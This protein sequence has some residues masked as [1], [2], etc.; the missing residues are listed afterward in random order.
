[1]WFD[2]LLQLGRESAHISQYQ[3]LM[4]PKPEP[5]QRKVLW[6]VFRKP[7]PEVAA[8]KPFGAAKTPQGEKDPLGRT[9]VAHSLSP[10]SKKQVI[11]QPRHPEPIPEDIPAPNVADMPPEPTPVRKAELK[12]F[13][14]PPPARPK[15]DPAPVVEPP[16]PAR[17]SVADL[18]DEQILREL[19]RQALEQAKRPSLRQFTPPS[20]E[21][22]KT[23]PAL[24]LEPP[25]PEHVS[26]ADLGDERILGELQRQG[27]AQG[28]RS[29][30]KQFVAPTSQPGA[31]QPGTSPGNA[32]GSSRV[33]EPPSMSAAAGSG[34]SGLGVIVGL[35]PTDRFTVPVPPGSRSGEFSR[36]PT[37]GPPSSGASSSPDAPRVP[38]V[39]AHGSPGVPMEAKAALPE[40][41]VPDRRILKEIILPPMNR[42]MSAPLRPS[43]RIVPA[44]VEARFAHRDVFAF[45]MPGPKLPGYSGNWVVWFAAHQPDVASVA[46]ILAPVPARKAEWSGDD[47]PA[48]DSAG[49]GIV[50]FEA[51]L[52]SKGRVLTPRVLSGPASESF[53]RRALAELKTW[54]FKPT[55]RNGEAIDVDVV[56]EIP[57]EFRPP[58]AQTR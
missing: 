54:E 24:V 3:V 50:Q 37:A 39:T 32:S 19:R 46:R 55:L 27:L 41:A 43:S 42:T 16:P 25:P 48:P 1:M 14:P 22:P 58:A 12:Q 5:H 34:G 45:V 57:F 18:K 47:G 31:S 33:I 35:N 51:V 23:T 44:T 9:I 49:K 20:A 6:Y 21:R 11:W 38:G 4:L 2:I 36:A 52:D 8:A 17:S 13:T 15:S 7:V 40:G 28:K 30:L 53:R 26:S 10:A 56:L 29:P